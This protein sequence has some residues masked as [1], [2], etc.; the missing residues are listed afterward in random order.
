METQNEELLS[1][2][3]WWKYYQK[4]GKKKINTDSKWTD[5]HTKDVAHFKHSF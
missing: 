3:V 1:V 2:R 4:H 5:L